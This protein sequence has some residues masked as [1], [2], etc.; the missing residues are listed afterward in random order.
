MAK[1]AMTT[2]DMSMAKG[3]PG[4]L[5]TQTNEVA[6]ALI[7]FERKADGSLV[8]LERVSTGG[9]GS[10]QR[11]KSAI[12]R[13]AP[14][15]PSTMQWCT[16]NKIAQRPVSIPSSSHASHSGLLRSRGWA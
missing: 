4:H 1:E 14:P 6:N 15:M 11:S 13:S 16:F 7:H 10:G 12:I 2:R 8:E 3:Q 5:Y 9:A